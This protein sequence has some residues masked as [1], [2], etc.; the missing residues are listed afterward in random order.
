MFG[1]GLVLLFAIMTIPPVLGLLWSIYVFLAWQGAWRLVGLLP[2]GAAVICA[3]FYAW[4]YI[5]KNP[6]YGPLLEGL[7]VANLMTLPYLLFAWLAYRG[8]AKTEE[9]T[10]DGQ[11]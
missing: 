10:S 11:A 4:V 8:L 6:A 3:S 2:F 1:I 5:L 9:Q 7:F